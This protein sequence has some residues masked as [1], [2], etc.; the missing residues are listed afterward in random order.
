MLDYDELN[1]NF[2]S[3]V[4][5]DAPLNSWIQSTASPK[6]KT[7]KGQGVGI[8]SLVHSILRVKGH[9]GIPG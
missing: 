9:V 2:V 6:V 8:F 7:R 5:T 4:F 1:Y 3:R